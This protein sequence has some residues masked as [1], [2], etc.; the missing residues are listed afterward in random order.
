MKQLNLT[1]RQLIKDKNLISFRIWILKFKFAFPPKQSQVCSTLKIEKRQINNT[2]ENHVVYPDRAKYGLKW[3]SRDVAE[4][5]NTHWT[6]F[7]YVATFFWQ[8]RST[9]VLELAPPEFR[10]AFFVSL[11]KTSSKRSVLWRRFRNEKFS[12]ILIK[13]YTYD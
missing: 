5:E 3:S 13:K 9:R 7:F 8:T 10:S 11:V 6:L 4:H 2:I 12:Y 1:C